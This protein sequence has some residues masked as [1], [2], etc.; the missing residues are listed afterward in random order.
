MLR[1]LYI[2][3]AIFGFRKLLPFQS[4]SGSQFTRVLAMEKT[5]EEQNPS[6]LFQQPTNHSENNDVSHTPLSSEA[7]IE[8][9]LPPGDPSR[10]TKHLQV[11]GEGIAMDELGPMVITSDGS[12][13]RISNW[14]SMTKAEQEVAWRRISKRNKERLEVLRQN[15]NEGEET[16]KESEE[17]EL[18]QLAPP[19]HEN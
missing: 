14:Q 1:V 16:V 5:G 4:S 2:L 3:F 17:V 11:G 8:K 18:K 12:I 10:A 7:P 15:E 19:E 13:R 9:L 6:S